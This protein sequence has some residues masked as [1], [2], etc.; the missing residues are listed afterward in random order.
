[1]RHTVWKKRTALVSLILPE[2]V[3]RLPEVAETPPPA[4][5]TVLW[6]LL[7][8]AYEREP[9]ATDY[10]RELTKLSPEIKTAQ[11]LVKSFSR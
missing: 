10:L 2:E 7:K 6:W 8:A 5:K 9:D 1:M 3:R 4:P 11:E